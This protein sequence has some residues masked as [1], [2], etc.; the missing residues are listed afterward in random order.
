LA[1][2]AYMYRA[3]S[4]P[5]YTPARHALIDEG[6]PGWDDATRALVDRG[7]ALRLMVTGMAALVAII[8]LMVLKPG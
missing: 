7:R 3:A 2:T 4:A 1:I 5:R 6:G 8:A